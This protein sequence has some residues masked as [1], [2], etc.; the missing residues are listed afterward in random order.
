MGGCGE[1]WCD[2]ERAGEL[3]PGGLIDLSVTF[4]A[5][6]A[7]Y[8]VVSLARVLPM[9]SKVSLSIVILAFIRSHAHSTEEILIVS[10]ERV[11]TTPS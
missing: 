8:G 1:G 3:H 2:E 5:A 6:R 7:F 10:M 11:M 9:D 4:P